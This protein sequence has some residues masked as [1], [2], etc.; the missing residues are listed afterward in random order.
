[1]KMSPE[2]EKILYNLPKM[3]TYSGR[4][5]FGK[6][7]VAFYTSSISEFFSCLFVSASGIRHN[8]EEISEFILNMHYDQL[9]RDL[10]IYFPKYDCLEIVE[11]DDDEEEDDEEEEY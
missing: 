6:R 2:L 5:M 3:T 9:G 8:V 7:C 4:G 10:I 11:A 1:M